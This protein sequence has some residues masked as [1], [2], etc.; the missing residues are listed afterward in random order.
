MT[1]NRDKEQHKTERELLKQ[2][3]ISTHRDG[4]QVLTYSRESSS[5]LLRHGESDD[6]RI[7]VGDR[8]LDGFTASSRLCIS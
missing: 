8:N 2:A 4:G 6:G 5:L 7:G 1:K 3:Q